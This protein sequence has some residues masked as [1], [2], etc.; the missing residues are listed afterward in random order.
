MINNLNRTE[1]SVL[2]KIQALKKRKKKPKKKTSVKRTAVKKT[3]VSPRVK[4]EE[5]MN[6]EIKS[7][8]FSDRMKA[9]VK[10]EK[11]Y[12]LINE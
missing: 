7:I 5:K 6:A 9:S 1:Q 11:I 12:K 8:V 10:L 3:N 4:R 2:E